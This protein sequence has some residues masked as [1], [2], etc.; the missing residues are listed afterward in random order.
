MKR[1]PSKFYRDLVEEVL[2]KYGET[3]FDV[4]DTVPAVKALL[5]K[6]GVSEDDLLTQAAKTVVEN[7]MRAHDEEAGDPRQIKMFD[8]ERF[9]ALGD[10]M[11]I[12]EGY[13]AADHIIRRTRVV[14]TNKIAQD[15]AWKVEIKRLDHALQAVLDDGR[16]DA[17]IRDV[18]E[19][20]GSAKKAKTG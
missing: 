2:S 20:D 1:M 4:D 11:R 8:F 13:M 3:E 10:R 6:H 18:L 5:K 19:E 16:Q 7:V 17:R 12:R 14:N 15:E 9:V